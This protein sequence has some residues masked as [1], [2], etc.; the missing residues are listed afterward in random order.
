MPPPPHDLRPA[1]EIPLTQVDAFTDQ[2]FA[3]NPAAVVVL[4]G[5]ADP[6]WMQ[7]IAAE[8]QLSETAFV[9]PVDRGW[10]LRWFTPTVE[11]TLCG[12]ATLA[13]AHVLRTERGHRDPA[14][15]FSTASGWLSATTTTDGWIELDFPA[16]TPVIASPPPGLLQAL[17]A[18]LDDAVT[19]V[20]GRLDWLIE[21]RDAAAVRSCDPDHRRLRD[22]GARGVMVTARSDG[23]YDIESRFFA[24]GSGIDEDPVT[25]SAHCLLGPFWA[26][27]LGRRDL[28]AHQASARGGVLRV[29]V[30]GERVHLAGHAVTVMRATLA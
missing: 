26:T 28:L 4:P 21:L 20:R 14:L 7:A 3:G 22:I 24:P 23:A 5:A 18:G 19:V 13:A 16:D 25:G 8:M 30:D 9:W 11:V 15:A 1:G 12:H 6:R 29:R 10:S 17:G 27:R 2:P